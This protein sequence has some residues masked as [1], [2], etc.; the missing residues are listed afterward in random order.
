MEPL[1]SSWWTP[2]DKLVFLIRCNLGKR[3]GKK[4]H[5]PSDFARVKLDECSPNGQKGGGATDEKRCSV[6][7]DPSG[8]VIRH[9]STASGHENLPRYRDDRENVDS[10][11]GTR[12]RRSR[13]RTKHKSLIYINQS[14]NHVFMVKF[15]SLFQLL[16]D[17]EMDVMGF[18]KLFFLMKF[19]K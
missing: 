8:L 15:P 11:K 14:I 3:N 17:A 9:D 4:K 10:S 18:A 2:T 1:F 12:L 7:A 13:R 6:S 5:I 19:P 16:N